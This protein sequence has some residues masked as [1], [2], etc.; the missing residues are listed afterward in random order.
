MKWNRLLGFGRSEGKVMPVFGRD[1]RTK[2]RSV[3][4]KL[5]GGA[6]DDARVAIEWREILEAAV[7]AP[8]LILHF[9]FC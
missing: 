3:R 8:R 2:H 1:R 7:K 6:P 4:T 5:I 9:A